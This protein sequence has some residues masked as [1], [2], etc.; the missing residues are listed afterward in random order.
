VWFHNHYW[1]IYGPIFFGALFLLPPVW[2]LA[3]VW[4]PVALTWQLQSLANTWGHNWGRDHIDEPHNSVLM[5]PFVLGDCWHA[6]HHEK[7]GAV[8]FHK[9]DPIGWMGETFF[10]STK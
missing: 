6:N 9:Y 8:R 4:A 7:P 1:H 5:F 10:K 2:A 3:L